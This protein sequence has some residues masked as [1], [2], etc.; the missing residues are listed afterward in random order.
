MGSHVCNVRRGKSSSPTFWPSSQR[1]PRSRGGAS[2]KNTWCP[3]SA[4][5]AWSAWQKTTCC[6]G[7]RAATRFTARASMR[8]SYVAGSPSQTEER[9]MPSACARCAR[10]ILLLQSREEKQATDHGGLRSHWTPQQP[11]RRARRRRGG[12]HARQQRRM[13]PREHAQAHPPRARRDRVAY[14][15][16]TRYVRLAR[17]KGHQGA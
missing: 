17:E 13:A 10:G 14:I 6:A 8:G 1:S 15:R 7:C 11:W 9:A 16:A 2:G 4:A 5:S 12:R 3:T